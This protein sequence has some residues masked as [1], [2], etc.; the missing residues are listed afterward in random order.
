MKIFLKIILVFIFII[1]V[2]IS[3]FSLVGIKTD[4]FN[5]NIKNQL[6]KINKD[7]DIDLKLI[8]LR[9]N[10]IEFKINVKI[11]GSKIIYKKK[12]LE[13]ESIK[14][15]ISLV[16]FFKNEFIIQNLDISTKPIQIKDLISFTKTFYVSPELIIFEKLSSIKG[17][18][19]ADIKIYFD[20]RGN[21][22]DNYFAKGYIKNTKF[23]LLQKL[24]LEK[25]NFIFKIE[26]NNFEFKDIEFSLN[27]VDF[28]SEK[29]NLRKMQ[30]GYAVKGVFSNK[31]VELESRNLNLFKEKFLPNLILEK[32]KFSSK[33]QFSFNLDK[34]FKIKNKYLSSDINIKEFEITN[35]FEIKDFFPEI[36]NKIIVKNNNVKIKLI[37]K[38]FTLEGKGEIF[39]QNNKDFINYKIEKKDQFINFDGLVRLD[40]DPFSISFLNFKKDQNFETKINFNGY[41]D[42]TK[43]IFLS[44]IKLDENKNIIEGSNIQFSS[45]LKIKSIDSFNGNYID[46]QDQ[47]NIFNIKKNKKKY[48]INGDSFNAE[49]LLENILFSDE[50]KDY[51][52][53]DF[54]LILNIKNIHLDKEFTLKNLSGNLVFK[55][56]KLFEGNLKGN[57]FDGK[58]LNFSARTNNSKTITTLFL[59][60]AEPIVKKY[61][62][63]KGFDGGI[64][65]FYSIKDSNVSSSTLKIYDFKLKELPTL[66]KLL[67]LASLQ[68]IADILTGEG[69]RFDEF[70]MKFENKNR[71]MNINEIYAI[72]PAISVLMNGYVEKDKLISL[73]GTLV[74]ATTI[75]KVIGTIPVLGK[76]LV[77]SKTGEGV[78]GVSF[79]VKGPPKKLETS[80]NP[81]KTLTPR[82]ITRTLE[83]IKN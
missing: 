4:Q 3:Y 66:T 72:G 24:N 45:K 14:T 41:R 39:L 38:N 67:T 26:K 82:F 69:I 71:L 83:K 70:E 56:R 20:N 23:N 34:N 25:L 33:N 9:L 18:L 16:S 7:I 12:V 75:N 74:P 80:V 77:G 5:T 46:T 51:F 63:I 79:K 65:D 47:K 57:F 76:I 35:N 62:F 58:K 17:F 52:N 21:I 78:F 59:D 64:L 44:S 13:T 68:G 15:E 31:I 22:K 8:N 73:R 37:K 42:S 81:I 11:L 30:Q 43:K 55:N 19:I 29:I 1:V 27:N 28:V 10:P 6:T 48:V 2:F 60:F 61:K 54:E 53:D 40:K 49:S 32:I 36:N 50:K